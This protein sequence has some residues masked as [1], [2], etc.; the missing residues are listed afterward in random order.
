MHNWIRR[1]RIKAIII[2]IIYA[3]KK[4]YL[5][6]KSKC[7]RKRKIYIT[8]RWRTETRAK[9]QPLKPERPAAI[10][11]GFGALS[12]SNTFRSSRS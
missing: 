5:T 6:D 3:S 7:R 2:I 8:R 4:F 10:N 11:G 9:P 12:I 1:G